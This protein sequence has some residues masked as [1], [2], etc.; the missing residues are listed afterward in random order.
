ML[1]YEITCSK[2]QPSFTYKYRFGNLVGGF[3]GMFREELSGILPKKLCGVT[4]E[5][6][7][8]DAIR[9]RIKLINE[10]ILLKSFTITSKEE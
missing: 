5:E 3:S 4:R 1:W 10:T 2:I 7:I 8:R 6:I 9:C